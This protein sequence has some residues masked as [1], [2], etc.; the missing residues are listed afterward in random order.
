MDVLFHLQAFDQNKKLGFPRKARKF[1]FVD[2]FIYRTCHAWLM[3]EG[4]LSDSLSESTLVEAIVASHCY[5]NG[6]AFYFK[7]EG[8]IDVIWLKGKKI[9]ALEVKW[10]TQLRPADIKMLR[11][12]KDHS[13]ILTKNI[14]SGSFENIK[15]APV[16]QFLYQ[17]LAE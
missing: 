1:H 4:Y 6:K 15:T 16:Y 14:H 2:P 10:S 11:N 13:L 12:Y 8:E 9:T 3:R 5:R 17:M 7:G